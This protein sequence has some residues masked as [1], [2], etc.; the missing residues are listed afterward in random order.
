MKRLGLSPAQADRVTVR[1]LLDDALKLLNGALARR[2]ASI[3][4]TYRGDVAS[5]ALEAPGELLETIMATRPGQRLPIRIVPVQPT[6]SGLHFEITDGLAKMGA[7]LFLVIQKDKTTSARYAKLQVFFNESRL[8][9]LTLMDTRRGTTKSD[10][11][12]HL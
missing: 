9:A 7:K 5:V 12:Y 4:I 1:L 6:L 10:T 3:R 8:V 11:E 2:K